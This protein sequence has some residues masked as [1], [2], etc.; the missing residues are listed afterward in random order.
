[1]NLNQHIRK[2]GG[3]EKLHESKR[4]LA[5]ELLATEEK[6]AGKSVICDEYQ[7]GSNAKG[8]TLNM[9]EIRRKNTLTEIEFVVTT[10]FDSISNGRLFVINEE[11]T[12]RNLKAQEKFKN[13]QQEQQE[14]EVQVSENVANA[15]KELGNVAKKS[16]K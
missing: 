4:E 7:L 12:E 3:I 13:Q 5:K 8:F 10:N 11:A 1:M 14:V 9:K 16:R 2:I 6:Y 15:L